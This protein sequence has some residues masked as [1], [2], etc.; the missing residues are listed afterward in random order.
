MATGSFPK[1]FE[2][3]VT[4]WR[5]V[6]AAFLEMPGVLG[7]AAVLVLA[8]N[9]LSLAVLPD[10]SEAASIGR[11]LL[12]LALAVAQA[13][14]LTPFAIAVHRYVL[15]GETTARYDL[16]PSSP[17]FMRFLIFS[18]MLQ[19]IMS[20]PSVLSSAIGYLKGGAAMIGI[21]MPLVAL[22]VSVV[23]SLRVL[24]LFPAVA[25][26]A[27]A[28]EWRNALADS[29]GHSWAILAVVVVTALPLFLILTLFYYTLMEPPS[30]ITATGQAIAAVVQSITSIVSL[31]AF[32][33]VASLLYRAIGH[34][35]Q[36]EPV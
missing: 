4:G 36:G 13:I 32:A 3:A 17:R 25:V 34:R 15:L 28:A 5:V 27:P 12:Y 9:L 23:I 6:L 8:V 35:L 7:W 21:V 11:D 18:I 19:L 22:V 16:N 20:V 2:T 1:I 30:G 31:G 14:V 33:A 24:I 26:D 10:A 29:K